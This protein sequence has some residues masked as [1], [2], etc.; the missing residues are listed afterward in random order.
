MKISY[1]RAM[2]RSILNGSL[3]RVET[4]P[5]PFFGIRVPVSCPG[6]PAEVL[7]PRNTWP[8]KHAYDRKA[9]DLAGRFT[10]NFKKYAEG[11]SAAVR[12][13]GPVTG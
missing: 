2:V 5:D 3:A 7:V 12:A 8:D 4:T 13:A 9:R 10:N 11:V 6:V 1:T